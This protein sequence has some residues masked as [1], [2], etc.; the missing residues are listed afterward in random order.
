MRGSGVADFVYTLGDGIQR[1]IISDGTVGAIK[2]VV[3]GARQTDAGEVVFLCKRHGTRKRT[4]STNDN[5]GI[6]AFF[7][8]CFI[9]FLTT[10]NGDKF[11]A[12]SCSQNGSTSLYDIA[13]I[14]CGKCLDFI[15]NQAL[16]TTIDSFNLKSVADSASGDRSDGCIH[17]RGIASRGQNTNASYFAHCIF[18]LNIFD[19]SIRDVQ[20]R[21]LVCI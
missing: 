11:L 15:M 13:D 21:L 1:G 7:L 12:A 5:E 10:F 4:I 2:V 3:N 9:G 19:G 20:H 8:Q 6:D 14:F 17:S 18:L 16:I